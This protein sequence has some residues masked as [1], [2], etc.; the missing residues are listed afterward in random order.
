MIL[1]LKVKTE[2]FL[3]YLNIYI[4]RFCRCVDNV[5]RF[6]FNRLRLSNQT[7]WRNAVICVFLVKDFCLRFGSRHKLKAKERNVI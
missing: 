1:E 2:N 7:D 3:K 6:S 5:C 4:F